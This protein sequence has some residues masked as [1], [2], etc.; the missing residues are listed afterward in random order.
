MK[1]M[2][3]THAD[4]IVNGPGSITVQCGD[5]P[6]VTLAFS[7]PLVDPATGEAN[8]PIVLPLKDPKIVTDQTEPPA[9]IVVTVLR[10]VG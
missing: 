1:T 4:L 3:E 7:E 6:P 10:P 5:R 9:V 2:S 8:Y